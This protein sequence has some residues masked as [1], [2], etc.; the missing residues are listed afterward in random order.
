MED[1]RAFE[2]EI[3]KQTNIKVVGKTN[4]S[5]KDDEVL[6]SGGAETALSDQGSSV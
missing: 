1:V 5:E 4:Q 3:Q 2:K 6:E